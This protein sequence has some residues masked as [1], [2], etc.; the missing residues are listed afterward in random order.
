[1]S[2][3]RPDF[4][5]TGVGAETGLVV[6][7]AGGDFAADFRDVRPFFRGTATG[8]RREAEEA[9]FGEGM[10]A[11]LGRALGALPCPKTRHDNLANVRSV[12]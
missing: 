12:G 4:G 10:E 6:D 2:S 3:G 7:A 9:E 8:G 11:V 1:L 5:E